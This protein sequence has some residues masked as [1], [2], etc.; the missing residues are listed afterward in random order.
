MSE[1]LTADEKALMAEMQAA[2]QQPWEAEPQ[3]A[4]DSSAPEPAPEA[5]PE[6]QGEQKPAKTVPLSAL[7]EERKARQ[8]LA[9]KLEEAERTK[10]AELAR[11]QERLDLLAQATQ[12][13]T[14]QPQLPAQREAPMPDPNID[15]MGYVQWNIERQNRRFEELANRIQPVESAVT[16]QERITAQQR[17]VQELV[18]WGQNQ[19]AEFTAQQPDYGRA[20]AF[21]RESRMNELTAAGLSPAEV[22]A[23]IA[24]DTLQLA[25]MARQRG[26]NFGRMLYS[27]AQARGY[28][29]ETQASAPQG[30]AQAALERATRGAA[31]A[32]GLPNGSA[33]RGGLTV[34]ELANMSE[35]QFADFL[36]KNGRDRNT[37]RR[38][39]GE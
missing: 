11:L 7:H 31:M 1:T 8:E 39:F 33:P 22:Q 12:A 28:K 19:E 13:M 37:L 38:Y 10:A 36:A 25:A 6:P 23:A 16:Q 35:A 29:P 26:Q 32:P 17:Q 4:P 27:L 15:P 30:T 18:Q 14:A 34:Q 9:R 21:L 20:T 24:Q 5:A 3:A 2:D